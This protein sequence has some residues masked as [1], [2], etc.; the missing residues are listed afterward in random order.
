MD[1]L[2]IIY[3]HFPN[4]DWLLVPVIIKVTVRI[5]KEKIKIKLVII[6]VIDV[7]YTRYEFNLHY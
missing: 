7:L 1:G 5:C 3:N 6:L 2:D 4:S